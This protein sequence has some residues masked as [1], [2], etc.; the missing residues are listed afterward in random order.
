MFS[1]L[2]VIQKTIGIRIIWGTR[3]YSVNTRCTYKINA[4]LFKS[5]GVLELISSIALLII[6]SVLLHITLSSQTPL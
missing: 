6:M 3:N 1:V 4:Y 2:L 5:Q